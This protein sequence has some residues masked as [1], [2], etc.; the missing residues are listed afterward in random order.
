MCGRGVRA[1][2]MLRASE[3]DLPDGWREQVAQV[4]YAATSRGKEARGVVGMTSLFVLESMPSFQFSARTLLL[5]LCGYDNR[6]D[7]TARASDAGLQRLP[8][9]SISTRTD[10]TPRHELIIPPE[11]MHG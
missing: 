6:F 1:G 5:V 10:M 11:N 4:C 9:F 3:A 7:S 8:R 2:V